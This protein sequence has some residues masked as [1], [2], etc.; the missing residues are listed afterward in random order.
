MDVLHV[1]DLDVENQNV[2]CII[3]EV[4]ISSRPVYCIFTW[5]SQPKSSETDKNLNSNSM[6][7]TSELGNSG[8]SY[9]F[10]FSSNDQT[11]KSPFVLLWKIPGRME[12]KKLSCVGSTLQESVHM[13]FLQTTFQKD[14]TEVPDFY[15]ELTLPT[16]GCTIS[17]LCSQID[18]LPLLFELELS[19]SHK[20]CSK[21]DSVFN[22]YLM[23]M[24]VSYF[25]YRFSD[26]RQA[27]FVFDHLIDNL[28][29]TLALT[30]VKDVVICSVRS[31]AFFI[32]RES[33]GSN[34]LSIVAEKESVTVK[35]RVGSQFE[36]KC[37]CSLVRAG[38][39]NAME[40]L[41]HVVRLSMKSFLQLPC[42]EIV[43]GRCYKDVEQ[44]T[45]CSG[46]A[47]ETGNF[48]AC[49][50]R[51]HHENFLEGKHSMHMAQNKVQ[52]TCKQTL[53]YLW[54][55]SCCINRSVVL[56]KMMPC[57]R[58]T[59]EATLFIA[60]SLIK[61]IVRG[62]VRPFIILCLLIGVASLQHLWEMSPCR[63]CCLVAL[64][65]PF[66]QDV[67]FWKLT[68]GRSLTTTTIT[69]SSLYTIISIHG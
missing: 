4:W 14:Y 37:I 58:V 40:S 43:C 32:F 66:A 59:H 17:S 5:D 33:S 54:Y 19:K 45:S 23:S 34:S 8:D 16:C 57:G 52:F 6:H 62:V 53:F 36:S 67:V 13:L 35:C 47:S 38:L 61:I 28:G 64:G 2:Y 68:K 51:R 22:Q 63:K 3:C 48:C 30:E 21:V 65:L 39:E 20:E 12:K 24:H 41:C 50:R 55:G 31:E 10:L 1:E 49:T 42:E 46:F 60:S 18:I 26:Q 7:V 11:K 9:L 44:E 27:E 15:M 69:Y 56:Q 25:L 29:K